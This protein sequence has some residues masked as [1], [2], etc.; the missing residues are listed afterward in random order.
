M[1]AEGKFS[2]FPPKPSNMDQTFYDE[3]IKGTAGIMTSESFYRTSGNIS[4]NSLMAYSIKGYVDDTNNIEPN[5]GHR[6]SILDPL[7]KNTVFGYAYGYGV[8]DMLSSSDVKVNDSFY[9]WPAPG[10]FPVEAMDIDAKWSIELSNPNYFVDGVIEIKLKANGKTYSFKNGDFELYYDSSYEAYYFD[11]PTE[12]KKYLTD[13]GYDFIEGKKVE[14]E[15]H[16]IAD[17]QGNTYIISYPINFF[18][19]SDYLLGDVNQDKKVDSQDAVQILKHVAHNITLNSTQLKA[20]DTN[21]DGKVD[22]QDAVQIL[23]YVAH[24]IAG[25]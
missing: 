15:V 6:L 22:S 19:V 1:A 21:K 18:T 8:V 14:V 10:N 2:H 25:F 9:S 24:N 7:A 5:V 20:A 17:D 23:K 11:I 16:N 12:L 13:G 4:Y 3:A